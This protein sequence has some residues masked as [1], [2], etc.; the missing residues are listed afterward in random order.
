MLL[1]LNWIFINVR[2]PLKTSFLLSHLT[3][4]SLIEKLKGVSIRNIELT[5]I[6]VK[7]AY[8][9]TINSR[10]YF[11]VTTNLPFKRNRIAHTYSDPIFKIPD[12]T[13]VG[14]APPL[15]FFSLPS[16]CPTHWYAKCRRVSR[17]AYIRL[18]NRR[19]RWPGCARL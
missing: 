15:P 13:S 7:K 12:H 19:G 3:A 14:H 5:S 10:S 9:Q 6:P 4:M 18:K 8:V 17:V 1:T 2:R 16:I 11:L